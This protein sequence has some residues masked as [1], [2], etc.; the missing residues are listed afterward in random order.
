MLG[1]SRYSSLTLHLLP[2]CSSAVHLN[3]AGDPVRWRVENSWG[4]N[5]C[6]RGYFLMT[7]AWF[8]QFVYQV[9]V[10]RKLVDPN[11][12]RIFEGEV[13]ITLPPYDPMGALA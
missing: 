13:D 6:V 3:D 9:V 5:A 1:R 7:D 8:D 12:R 11:L 4:P 2:V 10:D